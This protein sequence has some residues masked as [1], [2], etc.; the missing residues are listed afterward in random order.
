MFVRAMI[1]A[2][3]P[4]DNRRPCCTCV[5]WPGQYPPFVQRLF[6]SSTTSDVGVAVGLVAVGIP[7]LVVVLAAVGAV[8]GVR[9][10]VRVGGL[11][12]SFVRGEKVG[13]GPSLKG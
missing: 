6:I 3:R 1:L 8:V 9:V 13:A 4:A 11:V 7:F 5:R 12:G 2:S 10:W